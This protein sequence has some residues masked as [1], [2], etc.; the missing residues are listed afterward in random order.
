VRIETSKPESRRDDSIYSALLH[1][2]GQ[3]KVTQVKSPYEILSTS[4]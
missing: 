4:Y 2:S 3:F 1:R